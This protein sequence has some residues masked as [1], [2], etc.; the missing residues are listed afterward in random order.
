VAGPKSEGDRENMPR[1]GGGDHDQAGRG[2][3]GVQ[4]KKGEKTKG[5]R[6]IRLMGD[7]YLDPLRSILR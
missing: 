2:E 3:S 4:G 5:R 1:V 6:K 7:F